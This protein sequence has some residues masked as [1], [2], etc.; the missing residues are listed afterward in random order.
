[1][2][3]DKNSIATSI[4]KA[5]TACQ[6]FSAPNYVDLHSFLTEFLNQITSNTTLDTK[7]TKPYQN[8]KSL[9]QKN[10]SSIKQTIL[11]STAG[12]SLARA[13]GLSIYF[14]THQIDRSYMQTEFAECSQWTH[15]VKEILP[16]AN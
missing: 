15:F 4:K 8:L 10:I 3:I 5:R 13:Q 1:M 16:G 2:R 14:P 11:S 7:N 12:K 9:V 6:Q